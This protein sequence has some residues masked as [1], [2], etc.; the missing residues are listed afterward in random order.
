MNR[1]LT[2][3]AVGLFLGLAPAVAATDTPTDESQMPPAMQQDGEPAAPS[4]ALPIEPSDPAAPISG[5]A[6]EMSPSPGAAQ[7]SEAPL[8][9]TPPDQAPLDQS[10]E[11]PKSI[12]P[13]AELSSDNPQFVAK[14]DSNDW[15]ASDLIGES[16][17]NSEDESI[18]TIK[19]LVT[20]E[21]GNVVA[22]LIGTGGFLGIGEK[23]VAVRFDDLKFSRDEDND[24]TAMININQDTLASA[25]DYET[26]SDQRVTVGREDINLDQDAPSSN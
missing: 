22:V 10:T 24:V 17:V 1:L 14:Q 11:A 23:D 8:D 9:P 2:C 6:S 20:D 26:L 13:S 25:P 12:S 18:G 4:E 3:T 15:L 21:S 7:S 16:V 5:E 19:D